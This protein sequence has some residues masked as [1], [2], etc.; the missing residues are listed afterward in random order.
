MSEINDPGAALGAAA[1]SKMA[2]AGEDMSGGA[3]AASVATGEQDAEAGAWKGQNGIIT[4][5][6]IT[7]KGSRIAV[8]IKTNGIITTNGRGVKTKSR[9]QMLR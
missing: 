3:A 1:I 2:E 9:G 7:F 5:N 4:T 6:G 8:P